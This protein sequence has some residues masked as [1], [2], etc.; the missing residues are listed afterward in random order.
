MS[1]A[2]PEPRATPGHDDDPTGEQVGAKDRAEALV[3]IVGHNG[4][5]VLVQPIIE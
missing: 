3:V 2:P 1:D 5:F 4:S